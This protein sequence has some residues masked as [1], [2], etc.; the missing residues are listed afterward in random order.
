MSTE[1][2]ISLIL[3]LGALLLVWRTRRG[4]IQERERAREAGPE[5]LRGPGGELDGTSGADPGGEQPPEPVAVLEAALE[6]SPLETTQG[7]EPANLATGETTVET[8]VE[9]TMEAPVETTAGITRE[10]TADAE[11]K[12]GAESDRKP[13]VKT[14]PGPTP[15][16]I[17]ISEKEP[18]EIS[19]IKGDGKLGTAAME[20]ADTEMETGRG[21]APGTNTGTDAD[22][23]VADGRVAAD[24][25]GK[26]A[27]APAG[28][29]PP[30]G[31][32]PPEAPNRD[33]RDQQPRTRAAGQAPRRSTAKF[34]AKFPAKSPAD[35]TPPDKVD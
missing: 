14:E 34:P 26:P 18:V 30:E 19:A 27:M 10:T 28:K 4:L 35:R 11:K 21:M 5:N 2:T 13:A 33:A 15:E 1:T 24:S 22:G 8:T 20:D 17:S 23:R 29:M 31:D 7:V 32:S 25:S 6:T 12:P 16:P 9:T 3:F